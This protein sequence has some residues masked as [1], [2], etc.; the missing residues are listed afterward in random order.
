MKVNL[1]SL[2]NGYS[3]TED[4]YTII[5]CLKKFYKKKKIEVF[6]FNFN[7]YTC[8]VGDVTIFVGIIN[9][10][11]LKYSPI[12]IL[13]YDNH[14]FDR[15]WI[16]LLEKID[17]IITKTEYSTNLLKPHY[18]KPIFNIGWKPQ[19]KFVSGEKN[20]KEYLM[21]CGVSNHRQ[22]KEV[23]EI[24]EP[25]YP[26]LTILCG[27]KY[28]EL[29]EIEKKEQE[30]IN[31]IEDY[32][33]SEEYLKLI[34]KI[35]IH[36]CLSKST[37]ISNVMHDAITANSLVIGLDCQ[38]YKNYI[39]N[40][41]NGFLVKC[42]K[43]KLKK[44]LG[45]E[46]IVDKEDLK[47]TI[48]K[49]NGYLTEDSIEKDEDDLM[50]MANKV[51]KELM[52]ND[53]IFDQKLKD[54]FDIIRKQYMENTKLTSHFKCFDEDL[55]SVSII[56]PTH[57][58]FY[59]FHLAIRNFCKTDYPKDKIEWIIVDDST[60]NREEMTQ[61]I[62]ENNNGKNGTIKHI[63]LYDLK[64]KKTIGDKRNIAVENC[65]NDIIICMDDDDYYPPQSVKVRVASLEHLNCGVVGCASLGILEINKI[66][67]MVAA[68]SFILAFNERI[69]ESTLAFRKSYWLENKFDSSSKNEG[70]GFLKKGIKDL[71]EIQWGGVIVSL[72]HYKNNNYRIN[73]EGE[74][75]GSHFKFSDELFDMITKLDTN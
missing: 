72:K 41:Y 44:Y 67:S 11:F 32:L 43:V 74:T 46:Y 8:Q 56:T 61:L 10:Y 70:K 38:P 27:K 69:F 45:S 52:T 6:Y 51:K 15:L 18:K 4:N 47:K 1:I 62:E 34:N 13:I 73:V 63:K 58:R 49:V 66:I 68:S 12:N 7:T 57:N 48:E 19:D 37:N 31:F 64:K 59:L 53:R 20:F 42:N 55:P 17:Y 3:L 22:L 2:D 75:N 21:V 14:K 65:S 25:S 28:L 39:S 29:N 60:Q 71:N 23:L 36:L 40:N 5:N 30:N 50:E 9:N 54:F 33:K 24:W 16:P 26:K 35:G